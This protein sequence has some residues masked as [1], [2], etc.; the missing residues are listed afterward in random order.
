[1]SINANEKELT[2]CAK[3]YAKNKRLQVCEWWVAGAY[4]KH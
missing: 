1:M 2:G 3:V 4:K